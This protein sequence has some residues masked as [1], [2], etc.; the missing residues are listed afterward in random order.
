MAK[1]HQDAKHGELTQ[2]QVWCPPRIWRGLRA[3]ALFENITMKEMLIQILTEAAEDYL[4]I[5]E[6]H[7][8]K[9]GKP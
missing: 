8:R 6:K 7:D 4:A 9:G 3:R 5:L 1:I 2:N